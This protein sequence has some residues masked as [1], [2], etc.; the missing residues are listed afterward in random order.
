MRL[1]EQECSVTPAGT[2][3][4]AASGMAGNA[5]QMRDVGPGVGVGLG[6]GVV[7]VGLLLGLLLV[8]TGLAVG[9]GAGVVVGAGVVAVG[10][11]VGLGVALGV[12]EGVC[13]GLGV[14]VGLL[15]ATV[16]A[17]LTVPFPGLGQSFAGYTRTF[18]DPAAN[19]RSGIGLVSG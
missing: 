14:G 8:G 11:T 7:G 4:Q 10:E 12:G 9:D 18:A 1:P 13:V 5:G 2:P 19:T 17:Q 3:V 15:D 16:N 6:V